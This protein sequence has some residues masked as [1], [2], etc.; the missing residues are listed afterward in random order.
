[1]PN[2]SAEEKSLAGLLGVGTNHR[3]RCP[4]PD[5]IEKRRCPDQYV[6]LIGEL[7]R[8][9]VHFAERRDVSLRPKGVSCL[10]LVL[11]SPHLDEFKEVPDGTRVPCPANGYTGKKIAVH[12]PTMGF[13][14]TP[15]LILFNAIPFQCS[16]GKKPECYRDQEF[17]K[18]WGSGGMKY[19]QKRLE[20]AF[21][22]GDIVLNCCTKGNDS[23]HPHLREQV[24]AAIESVVPADMVRR[25]THP[26]SWRLAPGKAWPWNSQ[27]SV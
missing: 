9:G 22:P 23:K 3:E 20:S 5:Q 27:R 14:A 26:A 12:L 1:M 19:F 16:L 8:D 2:H 17:L 18:L 13:D 7:G 24:Q 21:L 4:C 25:N 15:G 6:G 11:E 10:F